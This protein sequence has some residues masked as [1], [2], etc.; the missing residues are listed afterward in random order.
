MRPGLHGYQNQR[1]HK[2]Q[3]P[4][5]NIPYEYRWKN[6]QQNQQIDSSNIAKELHA[7]TILSMSF[8]PDALKSEAC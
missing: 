1:H 2:R 3:K 7:M 6:P 4:Q 5:I 8:Y